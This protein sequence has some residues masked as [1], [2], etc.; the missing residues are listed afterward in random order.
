M[1]LLEGQDILI[2]ANDDPKANVAAL[3]LGDLMRMLTLVPHFK[4]RSV[5]WASP[6][7]LFSLVRDCPFIARV[8]GPGGYELDE[9]DAVVNLTFDEIPFDGLVIDVEDVLAESGKSTFKESV[10]D[11]QRLMTRRLGIASEVSPAVAT[12]EAPPA[13]D[14]G[15]NF[16]VPDAWRIKALPPG[17]WDQVEELLPGSLSVS[18]QPEETTVEDYVDWV[19]NCRL[20]LSPVGFGCHIA[21]FYG[22]ALVMLSGPTD[23]VEV[24]GY[25]SA[26][27]L[28]PPEPCEFRPCHLPTGVNDCGC[29][30]LFRPADIVSAATELMESW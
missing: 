15:I 26:R 7:N 1:S 17:H 30:P 14:V 6:P 8:V 28:Y 2:V 27:V 5:T 20:L 19:K 12:T 21:M 16:R 24:H 3:G 25:K 22:R 4:A 10:Y 11:L 29:M 18:R 23:F 13:Y 9:F